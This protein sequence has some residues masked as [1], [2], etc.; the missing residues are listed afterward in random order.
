[1]GFMTTPTGWTNYG[2]PDPW[3]GGVNSF[4]DNFLK[5]FA[6]TKGLKLQEAQQAQAQKE[7]QEK[8]LAAQQARER[9]AA[10]M[11]AI[12]KMMKPETMIINT[13]PPSQVPQG[14]SPL[15]SLGIG[16][17]NGSL[18]AT[19]NLGLMP[20]QAAPANT[21]QPAGFPFLPGSTQRTVTTR[22]NMTMD[23]LLQATLQHGTPEDAVKLLGQMQSAENL[24]ATLANRM[25]IANIRSQTDLEKLYE[26]VSS[27]ERI[28][29]MAAASKSSN[30]DATTAK[31]LGFIIQGNMRSLESDKRSLVAA[32]A[33][34][35]RKEDR[36]RLDAQIAA[37][38]TQ[39][40]DARSQ[41]SSL[42]FDFAKKTDQNVKPSKK[43][44]PAIDE[45]NL[46][47]SAKAA[48]EYMKAAKNEADALARA[49]ALKDQNWSREYM[50]FILKKSG[51]E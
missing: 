45:N 51:W 22:P 12:Q 2:G 29:Q 21:G 37:I 3:A 46:S 11:A 25:D 32:R 7:S 44:V 19:P 35:I 34:A 24:A 5:A 13:P 42:G 20:P 1:M 15:P 40:S 41:L 36:E 10:Y 14:G 17:G 27:A 38:D 50:E 49:R 30:A 39:L 18:T 48:I 43:G 6:L 26:K 9:Q 33:S 28:A 31:V 47:D 8:I 16:P 23:N 4:A